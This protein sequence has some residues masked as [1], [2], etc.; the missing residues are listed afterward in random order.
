VTTCNSGRK[1]QKISRRICL[2]VGIQIA[3]ILVSFIILEVFESQ[4]VFLGNSVN[5]SGK[6]RFYTA[7]VLSEVKDIY[8]GSSPTNSI[9]TLN[10]YENNLDLL[11]NGGKQNDITLSPLPEELRPQWENIHPMFSDYK[12]TAQGISGSDAAKAEKL[13]DLP[14]SNIKIASSTL[15]IVGFPGITIKKEK[16][17]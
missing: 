4:K 7:M 8:I 2:L 17:D 6:N 5:V 12:A 9:P 3:I 13:D 16:N 10:E 1:D 11:R 15:D 14:K